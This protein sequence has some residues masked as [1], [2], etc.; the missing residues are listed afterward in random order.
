M[1]RKVF[2]HIRESSWLSIF[3]AS[4]LRLRS[5]Y[6]ECSFCVDVCP[7]DAIHFSDATLDVSSECLG[8]A[9][10]AAACPTGALTAD[11]S[12]ALSL[13][14]RAALKAEVLE[15]ECKRVPQRAAAKD[16]LRLRCAG[17]IGAHDLLG[18]Y[19]DRGCRNIRVIDRGLCGDC[20]AS[21][22]GRHP[23]AAAVSAARGLLEGFGAPYVDGIAFEFRRLPQ[24]ARPL[25][26]FHAEPDTSRRDFLRRLATL[27][28][29]GPAADAAP[30]RLSAKLIPIQ[31][32]RSLSAL[33][34]VAAMADGTMP[35]GL[36]PKV[37]ISDRCA[38]HG[39][40]A[41]LCATGALHHYEADGESG[42]AFDASACIACGDCQKACPERALHL[43]PR[44][45]GSVAAGATRI[46]RWIMRECCECGH[47]FADSGLGNRCPPCGRTRAS[48]S[49][50]FGSVRNPHGDRMPTETS[51][52]TD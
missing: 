37:E 39:V 48:F 33:Q 19:A 18:V 5:R 31:K 26:A 43:M 36:F 13:L 44:G 47:K 28:Q 12:P 40:C 42:V 34:R 3:S 8:C 32:T 20:P 15:V 27:P 41:A 14:S 29:A 17:S 45:N 51:A 23:A 2:R 24:G 49:Q 30:A 25:P 21:D 7:V 9:R 1:A 16:A 38:D 10:C 11:P 50:L 52:G 4:C 35:S 22:R 6:S 46:T